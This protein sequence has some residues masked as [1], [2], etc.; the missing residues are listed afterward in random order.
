M[1]AERTERRRGAHASDNGQLICPA[2]FPVPP[3]T[4]E[5]FVQKGDKGDKGDRGAQGEQGDKGDRGMPTGQR[6]AIIYLFVL[7]LLLAGANLLWTGHAVNVNQSAQRRSGQLVEQKLCATLD[8]L[9]SLQPPPGNPA[10]NPS[11][12]YEQ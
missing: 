12:A 7:T 11:R 5:W 4:K 9:R 1:S 10:S 2:G 3:G 6:R 8:S